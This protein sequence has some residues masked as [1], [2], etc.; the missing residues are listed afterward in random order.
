MGRLERPA[1]IRWC[2]TD[3]RSRR[4]GRFLDEECKRERQH[5]DQNSKNPERGLPTVMLDQSVRNQRH[6][7]SSETNAKVGEPH[8]LA[9]RLVEPAR[10]QDLHGQR[11]AAYVTQRIEEEEEVEKPEGGDAA[12]TDERDPGHQ[13]ARHHDA[14]RAEAVHDPARDKTE[15]DGNDHFREGVA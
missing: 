11:A 4:I 6:Q 14:A 1:S 7:R 9:P 10:E 13:N 15:Q 5:D 3:L 8:R 12:Q 2:D